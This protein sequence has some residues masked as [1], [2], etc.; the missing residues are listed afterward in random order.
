MGSFTLANGNKQDAAP[1]LL[2]GI[3]Q[4]ADALSVCPRTLAA[5]VSAGK[6]PSVKLGKRRLFSVRALEQFIEQEEAAALAGSSAHPTG[7]TQASCQ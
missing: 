7:G 1:K 4:A 2:I 6:L 3:R 5:L